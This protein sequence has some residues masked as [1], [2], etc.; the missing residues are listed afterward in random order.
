MRVVN[1]EVLRPMEPIALSGI[2]TTPNICT[3][4]RRSWRE[5]AYCRP[6]Q[7]LIIIQ[8]MHAAVG[9]IFIDGIVYKKRLPLNHFLKTYYV[10]LGSRRHC[11]CL[12]SKA[13][14]EAAVSDFR[15]QHFPSR[16]ALGQW[17]RS[18]WLAT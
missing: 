1:I 9:Y 5:R 2:Q 10:C 6:N 8:F 13:E 4:D 14:K 18:T 15:S 12:V 7:D 16:G 11:F 17:M 3:F